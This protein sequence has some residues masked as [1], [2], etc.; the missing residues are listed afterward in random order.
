MTGVQ[1]CALSDLAH[2]GHYEHAL[3][4]NREAVNLFRQLATDRP[5]VFNAGLASSL[6]NF[7]ARLARLGHHE[8]ALEV[9]REAANFC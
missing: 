6:N 2:L 7:S 8:H 1:T 9:N 5:G 4:V 3:E